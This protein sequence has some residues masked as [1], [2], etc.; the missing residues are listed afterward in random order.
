MPELRDL[1]DSRGEHLPLAAYRDDFRRRQW[2]IDGDDSWKL[3]RGQ[4]FV[5]PG[6]PSWDAF[7]RGDWSTALRLIEQERE[8]L[9]EFSAKARRKN[10]GLYRLRVVEEPITP[11]L[12]WE[13]HLLN[14]R[15]QCGEAIRVVH[16]GAVAAH[17]RSEPLPELV[18][19]GPTTLYQVLYDDEGELAGAIRFTAP[20]L[21]ENAVQVTRHLYAQGEDVESYFQR[22]VAELPPPGR[23][24]LVG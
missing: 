17:E 10:I 21:V 23:N 14:L 11:Y 15:A 3:E 16:T 6:F 1:D 24:A 12:Q 2:T 5:E 8:W 19:L 18:T 13:L 9:E 7:A 20:D 4:H 22:K